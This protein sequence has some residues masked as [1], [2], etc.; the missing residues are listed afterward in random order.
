M[1]FGVSYN[2]ADRNRVEDVMCS[3]AAVVKLKVTFAEAFE[4]VPGA[5][6]FRRSR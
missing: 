5:V 4:D 3:E 1:F 6:S 2:Y